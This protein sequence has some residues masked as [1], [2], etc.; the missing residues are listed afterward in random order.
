M[1]K[2]KRFEI[3][4]YRRVQDQVWFAELAKKPGTKTSGRT[5]AEAVGRLVV[6]KHRHLLLDIKRDMARDT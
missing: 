1:A 2:N 5:Q 3:V 6:A 4:T